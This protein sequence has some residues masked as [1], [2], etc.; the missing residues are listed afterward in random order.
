[1]KERVQLMTMK[2]STIR[3][4]FR[5]SCCQQM[6]PM[7]FDNSSLVSVVFPFTYK[8]SIPLFLLYIYL[9]I[10]LSLYLYIYIFYLFDI[11]IYIYSIC[12][13]RLSKYIH[14]YILSI[15]CIHDLFCSLTRLDQLHGTHELVT[16]TCEVIN[17]LVANWF[18]AWRTESMFSPLRARVPTASTLATKESKLFDPPNPVLAPAFTSHPKRQN[19]CSHNLKHT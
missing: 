4:L 1:M 13:T 16:P 2:S 18:P 6:L 15:Y 14:I 11:Y 10:Y 3:V 9:Y 5:K 12:I 8:N 7:F 17:A 19:D